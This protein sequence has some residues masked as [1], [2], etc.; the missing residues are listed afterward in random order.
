MKVR[1]LAILFLFIIIFSLPLSAQNHTYVGVGIGLFSAHITSGDIP[2]IATVPYRLD[3]GA[4]NITIRQEINHFLSIETGI[5]SHTLEHDYILDDV[6][7]ATIGR[8]H[9]HK[10]P[11]KIE[12]EVNLFK[13][14]I[15]AY[16]SFGT[17][18]CFPR[19]YH[20]G[21]S[22]TAYIDSDEGS[23]DV[24]WEYITEDRY[25]SLYQV[26]AGSRFR[27]VDALLFEIELGYAISLKDMVESHFTYLDQS[28][29][30]QDITIKEGLNYWYLQGGISYPVQRI[31]QYIKK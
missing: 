14:R 25:Y 1:M 27:L 15:A 11:L 3:G 7:Y 8:F 28:T 9:V 13:D 29:I 12:M 6:I 4:F 19:D 23:L 22:Y 31:A 20:R 24:D 17:H 5:S 21:G 26:G 16:T 2:N 18:F 10:I 30:I